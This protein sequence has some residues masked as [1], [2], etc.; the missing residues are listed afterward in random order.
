VRVG[1]V[2]FRV[3]LW[4]L[5]RFSNQP[6]TMMLWPSSDGPCCRTLWL[7]PQKFDQR[8]CIL[9]PFFIHQK[10]FLVGDS[11]FDYAFTTC[12]ESI[13]WFSASFVHHYSS[14]LGRIYGSINS[15][16]SSFFTYPVLACF[17]CI[18]QCAL[19][20]NENFDEGRV[21]AVFFLIWFLWLLLIAITHLFSFTFLF[22]EGPVWYGEV[23]GWIINRGW[24]MDLLLHFSTVFSNLVVVMNLRVLNSRRRWITCEICK[25]AVFRRGMEAGGW[26]RSVSFFFFFPFSLHGSLTIHN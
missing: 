12:T 21:V 7:S 24:M 19:R 20:R 13:I 16:I 5:D 6:W 25:Q 14:F 23:G 2:P 22:F 26:R 18:E 10:F 9:Y 3:S 4:T 17:G 1:W 8:N 11:I 15:G